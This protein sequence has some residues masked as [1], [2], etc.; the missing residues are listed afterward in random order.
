ME[1][2]QLR[3]FVAVAELGHLTRAAERLHLSQ[4]AGSAQIKAL[5]DALALELFERRSSG[6]VLTAAGKRLVGEAQN[7]LAAAQAMRN[8]A[9]SMQG[10]VAG[11]ARVG[12]VSDPQFIRLGEVTSAAVDRYPRLEI[13]LSHEVT[14][15][16]FEKV[17]ERALDASF[18]YGE[19]AH[20]SVSGVVLREVTYRIAAPATWH[21]RIARAAWPEIA[22]E[23]WIMTPAI[24]T[25]HQLASALFQRHDIAPTKVIEAD[26]EFVV[27]S[28]VEAGLGVALMREDIAI[29]KARSGAVCL[30]NDVR[31]T[32]C[33][34][35]VYLRERENDP[36]IRALVDL[37]RDVWRLRANGSR[38][39]CAAPKA[40]ALAAPSADAPLPRPRSAPRVRR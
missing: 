5:E 7:L 4:P 8:Q 18:Y 20:P 31:L 23:P 1:L 9:R 3:S 28:L 6:M 37:L 16:A 36:V 19:L 12:T 34:R 15:A 40:R 26:D 24:S 25:H 35:F 21:E 29:D 39:R 22:A 13:Q 27:G 17:R 2:Y 10:E 30:W 33:L 38:P 11:V 32:T 14:G